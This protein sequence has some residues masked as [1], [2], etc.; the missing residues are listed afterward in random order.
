LQD[1][2]IYFQALQIYNGEE[3]DAKVRYAKNIFI[4]L[5][6]IYPQEVNFP[7]LNE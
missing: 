6:N 7:F 5:K 3:G 1:S 2:E 4:N